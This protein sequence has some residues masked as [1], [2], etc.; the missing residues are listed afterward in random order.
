MAL[1]HKVSA[2]SSGTSYIDALT[3]GV[4]WSGTTGRAVTMTIVELSKL[5]GGKVKQLWRF[6]DGIAMSRQLAPPPDATRPAK[7][8]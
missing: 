8:N 3:E 1:S 4:S 7:V 5:D 6:F 2:F